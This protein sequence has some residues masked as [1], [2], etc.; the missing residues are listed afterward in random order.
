MPPLRTCQL[1]EPHEI[2]RRVFNTPDKVKALALLCSVHTNTVHKWL[3]GGDSS[4]PSDLDRLCKAIFL[5]TTFGEEGVRG[6][7]LIA[8]YVREYFL[9]IIEQSTP[10]NDHSEL[11]SDAVVLLRLA[12]WATDAMLTN[13]PIAET[14]D[15]LVKLRDKADEVINR[16]SIPTTGGTV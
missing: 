14:L 12:T 13:Q 11:V 2:L 15:N 1:P 3:R 8:E 16:L 7:G 9:I 6:A 10:Y 4:A 5:A